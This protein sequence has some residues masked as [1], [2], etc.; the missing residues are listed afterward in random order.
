MYLP[1]TSIFVEPFLIAF[2]QN[3]FYFSYLI[4][5]LLYVKKSGHLFVQLYLHFSLPDRAMFTAYA[6]ASKRPSPRGEFQWADDGD[7]SF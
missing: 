7:V 1:L 5:L 2:F 6:S 3:V 4:I